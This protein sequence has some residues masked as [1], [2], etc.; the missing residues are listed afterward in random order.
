MRRAACI[1]TARAAANGSVSFHVS[2][3]P[4]MRVGPLALV[5]RSDPERQSYKK[6][7]VCPRSEHAVVEIEPVHRGAQQVLD[8]ERPSQARNSPERRR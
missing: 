7:V 1:S 2:T 4:R 3:A 8:A 5:G 6:R